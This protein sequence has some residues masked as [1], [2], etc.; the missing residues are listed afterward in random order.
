M[1]RIGDE[2]DVAVDE[3]D[4]V[5]SSFMGTGRLWW[6]SSRG[7]ETDMI[8]LFLFSLRVSEGE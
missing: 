3:E 4:D 2:E 1:K 5:G 6:S 7:C 8:L